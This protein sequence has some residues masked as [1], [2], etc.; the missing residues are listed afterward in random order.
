MTSVATI[1][2]SDAFER[3][4][5]QRFRALS[6]AFGEF[7]TY[8]RDRGVRDI[9][10]HL[11]QARQSGGER[12]S[13]ALVWFQMKGIMAGTL[14]EA[15]FE[16]TDLLSVS[17]EVGHLR[18]WYLQPVPTYLVVYVES[19]D[20]F[21]V[22]NTSKYIDSTWGRYILK[23]DQQTATVKIP[24]ESV[25]DKQAFRLILQENDIEQ[26]KKALGTDNDQ[27]GVC[28]RDY[29][30]IWSLGT[31]RQSNVKHQLE[32]WDWQSKARGQL[33]IKEL[34]GEGN[35]RILREHFQYRMDV[36]DLDDAYPHLEFYALDTE[37]D[38][39]DDDEELDAPPVT[40]ENGDI[41]YGA[42]AASEYFAYDFGVR[43]NETGLEMFEWIR[44]LVDA[45][46]IEID[47]SAEEFISIAPWHGRSV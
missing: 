6:A 20:T 19:A 17:L 35:Q 4:Y 3:T 24:R 38:W 14:P 18:Y 34:D 27:M 22:L 46:L 9:A 7:V 31:T 42:D 13:S 26:W 32:F 12:L 39:W 8:E 2:A 45:G 40:L 44:L 23:L 21:L 43:L 37:D 30:L 25:L 5:M 41:V 29:N 10:M 1:G 33:Y 47:D 11:T 36:H 15:Q 16:A 28:Y